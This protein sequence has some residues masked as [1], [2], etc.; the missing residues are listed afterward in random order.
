MRLVSVLQSGRRLAGILDEDRVLVSDLDGGVDALIASGRTPESLE[1]RWREAADV[2]L[3]AVLRP[4]VVLCAG[5]NYRDHLD[6]KAPVEVRDPE[7]FIKAGQTIA[8]PQD[9]CYLDDLVT[10]K[11]DYETE[12]GVVIGRPGRRILP[13][14]AYRHVFGYV[15]LNDLTARDRQVVRNRDGTF[16]MALGP[17]KN[18][19]GATRV[20]QW[21]V[22]AAAI[23]GDP[24][25]RLTTHVGDELRQDNSTANMVFSI[26]RVIGYLSTLITLQPGTLI[27][28]GTPG[29]TGW[30]SDPELGGTSVTPAGCARARYLIAG[31]RVRSAIE[32]V[33]E[34]TFEVVAAQPAVAERE[35]RAA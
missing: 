29:G 20:A 10:R 22:P 30:G 5:Q 34:L 19:D 14:D 28:T 6:E 7:F 25:L 24:R 33:G 4:P 1:G 27:A 35:A 16:T 2:Q 13:E 18:F 8:H 12:L 9:P 26:P 32:G 21:L 23:G 31:D 11:L 17:G 3:D 15:V